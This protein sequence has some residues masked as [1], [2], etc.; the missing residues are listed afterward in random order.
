MQT[1]ALANLL[2]VLGN[3]DRLNILKM[4]MDSS[5]PL[6]SSLIAQLSNQPDSSASDNLMRMAELGI[7]LR[8]PMGRYVF[9]APNRS[10]I[11]EIFDYFKE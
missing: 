4:L 10:L 5:D 2:R 7:V 9:Y 11:K 1:K 8:Q 6:P 3:E